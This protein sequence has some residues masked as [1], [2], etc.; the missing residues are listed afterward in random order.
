MLLQVIYLS[1]SI[2]LRAKNVY[3]SIPLEVK[4]VVTH[5]IFSILM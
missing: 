3:I 5:Y 1:V 2:Q 4:V